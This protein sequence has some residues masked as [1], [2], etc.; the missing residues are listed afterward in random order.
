MEVEEE[1]PSVALTSNMGVNE[2]PPMPAEHTY[3]Y[4]K[5]HYELEKWAVFRGLPMM[6]KF[7]NTMNQFF[8]SMQQGTLNM[9]DYM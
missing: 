6:M 2:L 3:D 9:P 8:R 1:L 5:V 4:Q 7:D